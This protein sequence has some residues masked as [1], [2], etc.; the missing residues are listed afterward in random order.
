MND[1]RNGWRRMFALMRCCFVDVWLAPLHAADRPRTRVA[2]VRPGTGAVLLTVEAELASTIEPRL[3]GLMERPSLLADQGML[4]VVE[5]A[6]PLSCWMFNTLISLDSMFADAE[7]RVTSLSA[8]VPPC[9]PPLRCPTDT[10]H[11][12][13]PFVL[14]W[15]A[16]TAANV[17]I[18]IGDT[19]RWTSP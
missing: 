16:G 10:S 4:C 8:A 17:G 2:G 15:N 18:D 14:E 6:Q 3:R 19:L 5:A 13:A 12:L 9:R 1:V 11:G 7:R